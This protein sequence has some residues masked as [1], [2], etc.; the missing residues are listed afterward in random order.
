[1]VK[2]TNDLYAAIDMVRDEAEREI[3]G[4]KSRYKRVFKKGALRVKNL[5]KRINFGKN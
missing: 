4:M 2:E 3:V 5:L 1:L